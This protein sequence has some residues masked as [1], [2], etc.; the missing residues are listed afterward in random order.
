MLEPKICPYKNT[1]I[2]REGEKVALN[3]TAYIVGL[4]GDFRDGRASCGL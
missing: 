2:K 3:Y 4:S 1:H